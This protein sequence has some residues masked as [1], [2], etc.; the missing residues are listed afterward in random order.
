MIGI[1]NVDEKQ[2][3]QNE[4]KKLIN[5]FNSIKKNLMQLFLAILDMTKLQK[6]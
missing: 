4:E 3:L 5:K 6:K 1:Y 2:I